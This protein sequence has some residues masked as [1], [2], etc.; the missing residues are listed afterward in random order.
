V[1]TLILNLFF[2][3]ESLIQWLAIEALER[4]PG[5]ALQPGPGAPQPKSNT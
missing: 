4:R 2:V 5:V 1:S 3:G